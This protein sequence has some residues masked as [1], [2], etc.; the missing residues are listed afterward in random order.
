MFRAL[1]LVSVLA[2]AGCG[3]RPSSG[4]GPAATPDGTSPTATAE[5]VDRA[6]RPAPDGSGGDVGGDWTTAPTQTEGPDETAR[7]TTVRMAAHA[8]YDRIVFEFEGAVPA[9]DVRYVDGPVRCGSGNE[10]QVRGQSVLEVR[11]Q[12]ARAH[13][14]DGSVGREPGGS[15]L[16]ERQSPALAALVEAVP[17]C[18]FEGTVTW[19]LGLSAETPYRVL[20][21]GGPP[22]IA[23]DVRH[24]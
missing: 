16:H 1:L 5:G 21:L 11:L 15:S 12:P 6:S 19:V 4:E 18:D 3:S 17:T 24:P 23:V 7:L 22:R 14:E 20:R 9:A 2:L 8:S 10:V 13:G